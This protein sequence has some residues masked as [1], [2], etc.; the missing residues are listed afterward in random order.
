MKSRYLLAGSA[1]EFHS[2]KIDHL[3]DRLEHLAGKL[4]GIDISPGEKLSWRNSIPSV[5]EILI[6]AGLGEV[7]VILEMNVLSND[8]R[9]DM[10]VV[11]SNPSSPHEPSVVAIENKQWSRARVNPR[12]QLIVHPGAKRDGS[13]HPAE[14][15][16]NYC[17]SLERY[18]PILTDRIHAAVNLHNADTSDIEA[19]RHPHFRLSKEIQDRVRIYGG[20]A[21][22]KAE[23]ASFLSNT[24]RPQRAAEHLRDI[25][26]AHVRPTDAF[27]RCVAQAVSEREM[28]VLLDEQQEAADRIVRAVG[29]AITEDNKQIFIIIGGPG[30]GKSVLALELLGR[31]SRLSR[32]AVHASGSSAFGKNLRKYVG[33]REKPI[34]EIFTY[35][36]NHRNRTRNDLH[37]LIVDEAH[38]LRKDSNLRYT[39]AELRNDKPQV[40]EI[41]EAARV[42]VFLLDPHQV[43]ARN[44]VGTPELIRQA[45]LELKVAPE[46]IHEITLGR[47]FRHGNCPRY[48]DWV[49]QLLGYS[50]APQPWQ[51]GGDF[52]LLLAESPQ[53]MENYLRFQIA[54]G[55]SARMVAGYCWE[56]TKQPLPGGRLSP[57]VKIGEWQRPWNAH[58]GNAKRGIPDRNMWP[59]DPKGFEQIGC[60]Y[61]AQNFD[62]DYAGL[63]MGPD[64]TWRE[65]GWT[66]GR[67]FDTRTGSSNKHDLIRNVYR[68]LATRGKYGV[69]L[70]ST[71]EATQRMLGKLEIP[72]L[73]AAL[74]DLQR[75]HPE[76]AKQIGRGQFATPV[77]E[78]FF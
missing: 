19:I 25:K 50:P 35:F 2:M 37:A 58:K 11:G 3:V 52:Q 43:V 72:S 30:T 12:T 39:K 9:I 75:L 17:R 22:A 5:L 20:D 78:S 66:S 47:Q 28:F 69:V 40:H 18:M 59:T 32:A 62:W 23:F 42:P 24:V 49:E 56:W 6:S 68:V 4:F 44:E 14:Q 67:N 45:A 26:H 55:H 34:A 71:D 74:S 13:L 73:K 8:A 21:S 1:A 7:M 57:D 38:R 64:Y 46:N 77:Q 61:T 70:F 76:T 53:D 15:V 41:I 36:H 63:I 54:L 65:G 16:W 31:L 48:V 10:L 60:I 33:S 29:E 51:Q 27:M